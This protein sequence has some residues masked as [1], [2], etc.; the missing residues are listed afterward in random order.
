MFNREKLYYQY[1][2][3]GR[4]AWKILGNDKGGAAVHGLRL[5]LYAVNPDVEILHVSSDRMGERL[6]F[7]C[8]LLPLH[9]GQLP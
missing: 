1:G 7:L 6:M 4:A 2:G 8:F 3:S 9:Q 5:E